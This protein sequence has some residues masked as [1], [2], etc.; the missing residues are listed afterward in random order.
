VKVSR[1]ISIGYDELTEKEWQKLFRALTF[2]NGDGEIVECWKQ[3]Y[4]RERVDIPRGAWNLVSQLDYYDKRVKPEAPEMKFTVQLDDVSKDERFGDQTLALK[5]MLL[6]EQGQ[7]IRPPGTGKS[8]IVLAFAA[9]CKT[10]CLVIVHTED[11]LNQWIRYAEESLPGIDVGVIRGSKCELRQLTIGTIQTLRR[12]PVGD[13]L[14]EKFGAVIADEAHHGAAPSWEVV[15]NS[16]PAFYR[17]GMTASET[18]AD[19]MHP[20]LNFIIG[21]VIH[22]QEFSSP[23]SLRVKPVRTSFYFGF[24]GPFDWMP[25]LNRLIKD[26][27]RNQQIADIATAEI[28]EGNSILVLSRRIEHLERISLL[29]NKGEFEILTGKRDSYTRKCILEDFRDGKLK[30]LLATQL[31][32]EAL[33]V[34]RLNRVVLTHPGKHEGRLIQQIGRA[35][36]QH[37][38]KDDAVI[39]DVMDTRVGVLRRQWSQRKQA[40]KK[41]GIRVG[42]LGRISL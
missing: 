38:D 32:D 2:V 29:L 10:T 26:E 7:I 30:C 19:G 4:T 37:P 28:Q 20:A 14:W 13:P 23:V 9:Q 6:Q 42:K 22:K 8:Q 18:R 3:I 41:A 40:Y 21:P 24:R 5:S 33:D 17:F 25:M 34:P 16:C 11:I 15:M 1:K 12:F 27:A 36:R 31:A 39:Y 35:I